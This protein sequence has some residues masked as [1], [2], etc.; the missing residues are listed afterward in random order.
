MRLLY[1]HKSAE[2]TQYTYYANIIE[3]DT[4]MLNGKP[5]LMWFGDADNDVD[6]SPYW[7]KDPDGQFG[8]R[9]LYN[10]KPINGE[11]IILASAPAAKLGMIASAVQ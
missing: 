11:A 1:T 5:C 3:D 8:T 2:N 10:G 4:R 7:H 6:G 9:W